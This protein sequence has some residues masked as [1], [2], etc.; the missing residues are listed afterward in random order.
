MLFKKKL[1]ANARTNEKLSR[2]GRLLCNCTQGNEKIATIWCKC[3]TLSTTT[4]EHDIWVHIAKSKA[5]AQIESKD[6]YV[7]L[8]KSHNRFIAHNELLLIIFHEMPWQIIDLLNYW[9]DMQ[10]DFS[11]IFA[12]A[13]HDL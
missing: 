11:T 6:W 2:T 13:T 12:C 7:I 8:V 5:N 1:K 9:A 3:L 10:I 4:Y